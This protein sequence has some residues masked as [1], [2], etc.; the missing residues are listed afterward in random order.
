MNESNELNCYTIWGQIERDLARVV[1]SGVCLL[2]ISSTVEQLG[3]EPLALRAAAG[4]A[5]IF[6]SFG[7]L[8]Q[9]G[10]ARSSIMR[11]VCVCWEG[12]SE[13][14]I[15]SVTMNAAS[16]FHFGKAV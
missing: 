16:W 12:K 14:T 11:C 13:R 8:L 7:L 9:N 6:A 5:I 15:E 10:A 1:C 4:P 2:I 3:M